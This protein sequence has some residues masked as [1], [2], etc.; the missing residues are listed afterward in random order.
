MTAT[1]RILCGVGAAGVVVAVIA[2]VYGVGLI[3][4]M[5][6]PPPHAET[7]GETFMLGLLVLLIP[8]VTS[9]IMAALVLSWHTLYAKCCKY[10][11]KK[12]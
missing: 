1:R 11:E 3:A 2:A 4:D 9:A 5:F 6:I 12:P 7:V 10:W 8:C